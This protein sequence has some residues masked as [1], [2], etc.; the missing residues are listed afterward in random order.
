M[1]GIRDAIKS[2]RAWIRRWEIKQ[3]E[4]L[5]RKYGIEKETKADTGTT[6]ANGETRRADSA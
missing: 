5:K 2:E 3:R 4:K 6:R 1:K